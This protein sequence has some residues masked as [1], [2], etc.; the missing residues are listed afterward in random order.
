M[1]QTSACAGLGLLGLCVLPAAC[2]HIGDEL[3]SKFRDCDTCPEMVVIPAGTFRMGCVSGHYCD[4]D[5]HPVHSVRLSRPFALSK[6][7]VTFDEYDRFA[8]ATGRDRLFD[9]GWGRGRRP[10]V[11]VSW[12]DAQEYVAWLTS[13]TGARYRL[14]SEAEWE[15]AARAGT[16]TAYSW[17]NDLGNNRAN[18]DGCGSQWDNEMTAP[19]GSF[20]TNAWGLHD[21]HG[22]VR[23]WVED[24][25]HDS[26]AG[27]PAD[28]SAWTVGGDC[29]RRVLRGGSW[30]DIP[31]YLRAALRSGYFAG[32]RLDVL[33][34]RVARTLD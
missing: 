27:A 17:G 8:A 9:A 2:G 1:R 30:F 7:E 16:T 32:G 24:C 26:Y 19:V 29:S 18:C 20:G 28:G 23:E 34:F 10:V 3:L 6:H 31:W 21:M 11:I 22:N 5:E 13:E 25:W 15:Y 12:N 4:F 33:G 14:P